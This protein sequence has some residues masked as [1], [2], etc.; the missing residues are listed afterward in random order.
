MDII[1]FFPL[2]PDS[3]GSLFGIW[4]ANLPQYMV[5]QALIP[6]NMPSNLYLS[7]HLEP[8]PYSAETKTKQYRNRRKL[9]PQSHLNQPLQQKASIINTM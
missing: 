2:A 9:I 6:F 1:G 8:T 3:Y 7:D 5:L 4:G